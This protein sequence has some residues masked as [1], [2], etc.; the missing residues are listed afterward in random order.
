MECRQSGLTDHQWCVEHD[1]KPGT[2]YNWVKGCVRKVV[3]ICQ[4]QP[5]AAIVHRK[6]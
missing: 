4:H 5:D 3:W 2:F 6:V 1:I